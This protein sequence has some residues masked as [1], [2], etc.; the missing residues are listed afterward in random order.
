ML[1]EKKK[2]T[3]T[4]GLNSSKTF[5][6]HFKASKA[7][8]LTKT[9]QVTG[10]LNSPKYPRFGKFDMDPSHGKFSENLDFCFGQIFH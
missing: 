2:N 1:P 7:M 9:H 6:G 10:H 3:P 4:L 8:F 5:S